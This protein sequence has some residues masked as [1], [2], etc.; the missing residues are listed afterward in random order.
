MNQDI[1]DIKFKATIELLESHSFECCDFDAFIASLGIDCIDVI[2]PI[3]STVC[4]VKRADKQWAA[5]EYGNKTLVVDFGKYNH[6]WGYD[7]GYCLV[8]VY[9]E[10]RTTFANRGIIDVNGKEVVRP[11]TYIDIL[12]FYGR[13]DPEIVA[14]TKDEIV[15]LD[16]NNPSMRIKNNPFGR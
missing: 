9:D 1:E 14:L 11:Y 7:N 16:R 5:F 10:D 12:A 15:K 6:M 2:P 8:S 4:C 13:E 3:N